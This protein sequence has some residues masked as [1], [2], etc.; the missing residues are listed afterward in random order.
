[1]GKGGCPPE[2][3]RVFLRAGGG[4]RSGAGTAGLLLAVQVPVTTNEDLC[5]LIKQTASFHH[6]AQSP[7]SPV[8]SPAV[9]SDPKGRPG[10]TL[11]PARGGGVLCGPETEHQQS[12]HRCE[13][14]LI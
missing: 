11:P 7:W 5:E 9:S 10:P 12:E 13:L 3:C 2:G 4:S 1:M 14:C 6:L 8:A